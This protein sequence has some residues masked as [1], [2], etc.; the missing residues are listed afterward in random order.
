M[1]H[2][3]INFLLD[4]DAHALRI[5]HGLLWRVSSVLLFSSLEYFFQSPSSFKIDAI[6][7]KSI[8]Q[9]SQENVKLATLVF[10][11]NEIEYF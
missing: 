7:T 11:E 1:T 6:F 8:V 4:N 9:Q 2:L 3:S 5:K 10:V